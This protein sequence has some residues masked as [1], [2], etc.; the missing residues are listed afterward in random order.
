MRFALGRLTAICFKK[1]FGTVGA[2]RLQ[3]QGRLESMTEIRPARNW[4]GQ[5]PGR[6]LVEEYRSRYV[7][8]GDKS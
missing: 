1:Q 8:D 2:R 5:T 4:Q 6:I 7:Q 3:A